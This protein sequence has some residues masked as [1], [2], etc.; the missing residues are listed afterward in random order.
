MQEFLAYRVRLK[1][2]KKKVV[3]EEYDSWD[4]S[5]YPEPY[6][7]CHTKRAPRDEI[8]PHEGNFQ[9]PSWLETDVSRELFTPKENPPLAHDLAQSYLVIFQ[10]SL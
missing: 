5:E 10:S 7:L 8:A 2:A 4:G 3:K 6:P 1:E 9:E